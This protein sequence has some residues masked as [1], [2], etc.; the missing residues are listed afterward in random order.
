[1]KPADHAAEGIFQ[2]KQRPGAGLCPVR[3]C[4]NCIGKSK[5][6]LC[7]KH[8]QQRW[9]M[10][11]KKRSAYTALRDNAKHR[12][13]KF[14]IS[15]DYWLGLTDAFRFFDHTA[16]THGEK[17]SIDR[18]DAT[19]GYEPGN[20]TIITVAENTG[21]GN[22]ERHLPAYVQAILERKRARAQQQ[23]VAEVPEDEDEWRCPF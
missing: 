7:D 2:L 6:G 1:M 22:A 15:Y 20:V 12:G 11:D 3:G 8:Y 23:Q 4:R 14:T 19:R 9:R 5:A 21:K 10:R 17:L 18:I 13:I 16:E